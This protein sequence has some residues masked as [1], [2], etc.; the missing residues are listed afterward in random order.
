MAVQ[1]TQAILQKEP[2][3]IDMAASMGKSALPELTQLAHHQQVSVRMDA[4]RA[5]AKLDISISYDL[6]F[7]G[8]DDSDPNV[9]QA[10]LSIIETII[11]PLSSQILLGLLNKL[12]LPSAKVRVILMLGNTLSAN[13]AIALE[14]YCTIEHGENV[15]LHAIVALAKAGIENRRQQFAA[16]LLSIKNNARLFRL[17]FSFID[18]IDQAW[19][20]PSL[21]QLLTN[22]MPIQTL[23]ANLPD[24]PSTIRVCDNAV[25][26]IASILQQEMSFSVT[27]FE[28]FTDKQ[29]NEVNKIASQFKH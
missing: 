16:Y 6:I 8:L 21:R 7:K 1:L 5:L 12:T 26:C 13:E 2:F 17:L 18:Y 4:I 14:K 9:I 25:L 23:S 10:S 28:N 29:L 22:K 15:A 24:I 11:P 27:K 3:A 20:L 19:L